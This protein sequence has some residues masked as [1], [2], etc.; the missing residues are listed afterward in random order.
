[1]FLDYLIMFVLSTAKVK[2]RGQQSIACSDV[3]I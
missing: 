2:N 1:M 3:Y